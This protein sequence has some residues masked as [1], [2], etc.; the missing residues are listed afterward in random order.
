MKS[1]QLYWSDSTKCGADGQ[2]F[3]LHFL[4]RYFPFSCDILYGWVKLRIKYRLLFVAKVLDF[5]S[6]HHSFFYQH[7]ANCMQSRS[8]ET[9]R[10]PFIPLSV[11]DWLIRT[12]S[13]QRRP[14]GVTAASCSQ[15]SLNLEQFKAVEGVSAYSRVFM[16]K[17]ISQQNK[18]ATNEH[19]F[20]YKPS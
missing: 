18:T 8:E 7:L 9:Q 19:V 5:V 14:N 10:F 20:T 15:N 13:N 1:R 11:S 4:L 12:S 6:W 17:K 16:I 2:N 3:A